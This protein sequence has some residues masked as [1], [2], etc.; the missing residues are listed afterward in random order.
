MAEQISGYY[1]IALKLEDS[2]HYIYIKKHSSKDK[3]D[4]GRTVFAVNLPV[5]ADE[6]KIKQLCQ[7][8][9]N[10]ILEEFSKEESRGLIKLVDKTSCNRFINQ[11]KSSKSGQV[12]WP[13]AQ[14]GSRVFLALNRTRY[15]DKSTLKNQVDDYMTEFAEAEEEKQREVEQMSGQVDEDGFIK[16]VASNRKSTAGIQGPKLLTKEDIDKNKKK[17]E[18][19]DFYRFQLR[20]KKK[21][22]MNNLL[23]RYQNDKEKVRQMRDKRRFKPY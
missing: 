14:Y 23:K 3:S 1:P 9:G 11:A 4:E 17:K 2:L 21:E 16:V 5:D 19:Q 7:S 20:Q 15:V 22:E 8:F 13:G 12:E 10:T 6:H 18:K